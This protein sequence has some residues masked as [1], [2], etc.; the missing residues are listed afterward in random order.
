MKTTFV[1]LLRY[2]DYHHSVVCHALTGFT[3][4]GCWYP[5]AM[6]H[7]S[8]ASCKLQAARIALILVSVRSATVAP[9]RAT[10]HCFVFPCWCRIHHLHSRVHYRKWQ[11]MSLLC[12]CYL[13]RWDIVVQWKDPQYWKYG[14]PEVISIKLSLQNHPYDGPSWS[15]QY[16][17]LVWYCHRYCW[18][19]WSS[20]CQLAA[21][22]SEWVQLLV[23]AWSGAAISVPGSV[24]TS[25]PDHTR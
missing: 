25:A 12:Y 11:P 10:Y 14:H 22:A 4:S 8:A 1:A 7:Y 13:L 15:F 2:S 23:V 19:G 18:R 5:L 20:C 6:R 24:R 17:S 16:T 3:R 21:T 9:N